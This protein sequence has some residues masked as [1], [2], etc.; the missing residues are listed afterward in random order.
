[1]SNNIP[2]VARIIYEESPIYSGEPKIPHLF[3]FRAENCDID[4][5]GSLSEPT[6]SEC[7]KYGLPK[8]YSSNGIYLDE[9]KERGIRELRSSTFEKDPQFPVLN[10][11]D[12]VNAELKFTYFLKKGE[13]SLLVNGY[14]VG[15]TTSRF[16]KGASD[17]SPPI[18][19]RMFRQNSSEE[20]LRRASSR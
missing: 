9:L 1:M 8:I 2:L 7:V 11:G 19:Q 15:K 14:S 17:I 3:R 5:S 13:V 12:I 18:L 20:G 4:S 10:K 6:L 16:M